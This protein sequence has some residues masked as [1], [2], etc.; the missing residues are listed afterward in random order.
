MAVVLAEA[1]GHFEVAGL[2]EKLMEDRLNAPQF[3][4]KLVDTAG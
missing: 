2:L 4:S 1:N 3:Y